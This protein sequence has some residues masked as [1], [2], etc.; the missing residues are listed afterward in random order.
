MYGSAHT[1]PAQV[2]HPKEELAVF[3]AW[4][5][6]ITRHLLFNITT[7]KS[8][9]AGTE[10]VVVNEDFSTMDSEDN[11]TNIY[12]NGTAASPKLGP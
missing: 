12:A 10:L 8:A 11:D 6:R 9:Q 7:T 2:S 5:T 4:R 1:L 3:P